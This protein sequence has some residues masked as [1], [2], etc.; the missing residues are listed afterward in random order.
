M[1]S[2]YTN[3]LQG[4]AEQVTRPPP[5]P[6]CA[7]S[8]GVECVRGAIAAG[9]P[10][11]PR[12]PGPRRVPAPLGAPRPY[13][14]PH[15]SGGGMRALH[16]QG[17][18][19]PASALVPGPRRLAASGHRWRTES[20]GQRACAMPVRKSWPHHANSVWILVHL[21]LCCL[22][23]PPPQK[24]ASYPR[25]FPGALSLLALLVAERLG[26]LRRKFRV[27]FS[28]TLPPP[29]EMGSSLF[30]LFSPLRGLL[31]FPAHSAL[32]LGHGRG[33]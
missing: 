11:R 26:S 1:L 7:L 20:G 15:R 9:K 6:P 4:L 17:L 19:R 28:L 14:G 18:E 25:Q 30:K 3:L 32:P 10:G 31:K 21:K 24:S 8:A 29:F 33:C 22:K 16:M 2:K 5:A 27:V 13:P 12:H 23:T